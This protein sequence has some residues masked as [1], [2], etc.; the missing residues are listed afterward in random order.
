MTHPYTRLLVLP[1]PPDADND[2]TE[3]YELGDVVHV[4]GGG[5]YDCRDATE[6]AA[7][8]EERTGGGG[9]D[10]AGDTHAA[11]AKTTPHND[12]EL[13]LSDSEDSWSLK[14]VTFSNIKATL[15]AYFDFLY[16]SLTD[17]SFHDH[18]NGAGDAPKLAQANT[19]QSADTDSGTSSL[20]HT[21]GTGANQA[22]AG[23]RGV[24]NGDSHD[25]NGGDGGAIAY[26]SLSGALAQAAGTYTPTCTAVANT[27]STSA[28]IDF[29]YMRVGN[30]VIVSGNLNSD[31]TTAGV[32]STI[33]VSLPVASDLTSSGDL[34]GT[35]GIQGSDDVVIAQADTTNDAA[36]V[37][38]TPAGT[39]NTVIRIMFMYVV[40]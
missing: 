29:T 10:V 22:A 16:T 14:K 9:G 37:I 39:A 2:I 12:D 30:S 18:D 13:P 15:A 40:K 38:Y 8:W 17:Y 4:T 31:A 28:V 26:S 33:R 32:Q 19:H 11:A 34:T 5:V 23:T 7:V 36:S 35:G 24:T 6:G 3:G 25:H 21:I 20:H 1:A 27:D